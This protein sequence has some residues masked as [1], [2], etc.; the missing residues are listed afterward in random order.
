MR[1]ALPVCIEVSQDYW[2]KAKYAIR[3]LLEPLGLGP[4]FKPRS[5]LDSHGLYYGQNPADI[6][7]TIVVLP[8]ARNAEGFYDDFTPIDV[9]SVCWRKHAD[10]NVP[11]LFSSESGGDLVASAFYWLSGWQEFTVRARD[12]H[13]RFPH[14]SSLQ[15]ILEVTRL[16]VVD[17]YR[18]MLRARLEGAG[19]NTDLRKWAGRDWAFCPTIDVDYLRH[20]RIGMILREKVEYFLLN[21]RK[22]GVSER[23]RRLFKFTHS[24]FSRGDAFKIALR[25]MYQAIRAYGNA[26]IFLKAAA[27]GPNDVSYQLDQPFIRN[28]FVDLTSDGFEIGLHPSYHAHT[29]IAYVRSERRALTE[30][31]GTDPLSVRQHFLRYEPAITPH[32][33]EG[34]GFRI[35]SS[36][37][38]AECS[39]FRNGTC[40]PFLKFDPVGNRVMDIWE[41]PLLFMDGALFNRQKYGTAEAI[42]ESMELLK[43]CQM[44]GGVA[45]GLWHNVIGEELDYPGWG[46]HFE[47]TLGWGGSNGAYIASLQDALGAWT[48]YPL[49]N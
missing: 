8:L 42:Q 30:V 39:G 21:R 15:A 6:P 36:L 3:M 18:T 40:M 43:L 26:T 38:F 12:Q 32:I 34:V 20:W 5:E 19:I 46:E 23:W 16:P 49:G 37:G 10:F 11:I 4:I 13:G 22:V 35:D 44:F 33:Q 27:H 14:K 17:C 41:M 25:N 28:L 29:H 48:G 2:P 47:K 24:Y 9:T 31:T 7:S 45:V 1:A